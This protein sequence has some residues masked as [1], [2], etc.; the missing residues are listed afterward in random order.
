MIIDL[1]CF[2]FQNSLKKFK[3]IKCDYSQCQN[4]Y[5]KSKGLYENQSYFCSVDCLKSHCK[6][7]NVDI[8]IDYDSDQEEKDSYE[9]FKNEKT[10]DKKELLDSKKISYD[11]DYDPMEDFWFF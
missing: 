4:T 7:K 9:V 3:K 5:E 2:I 10:Q 6:L 1:F 11:Y 8:A